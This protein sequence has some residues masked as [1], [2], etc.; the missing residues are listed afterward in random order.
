MDQ[1]LC[2]QEGEEGTLGQGECVH[3]GHKLL[4]LLVSVYRLQIICFACYL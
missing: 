2:H 3:G 4:A 1:V